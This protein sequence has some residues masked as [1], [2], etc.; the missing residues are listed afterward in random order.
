[1]HNNQHYMIGFL[2]CLVSTC[3]FAVPTIQHWQ[4]KSG[5]KVYFVPTEGLPIL[6]VR[7]VFDAGSVRDGNQTGVASLTNGMLNEG[8]GGL[9][10]QQIAEQLESVGAQL[11]LS[12]SR[13]FASISYRSLTDA[14]A[15]K[16][17]W[18]VLK[19]VLTQPRFPN[20]EFQ[21]VKKNT[22]LGIKKREESP[23]TLAQL[24]LYKA[25]FKNHPYANAI[26]GER[27]SVQS[28]EQAD[29]KRFYKQYYVANN[30]VVV[31]VGGVERK[32]AEQL[33]SELLSELPSGKKATPIATVADIKQGMDIHQEYPSQQTHLMYGM[34]VLAHNDP[35][36]FPL[37]VGNH[38]LGGSGFGSRIVKDIREKRGLAYSAYSYFHPM[39]N[40]GPFLVGL[41]TKNA[42]VTEAKSAI[43][44]VLK[45]FI[46]DGPTDEELLASKK[47]I[48]GGFA[49]K[50]DSNKKLLASVVG[51]VVSG[52]PLDY[53]NSYLQHVKAV[54]R[55]QIKEAFQRRIDMNK[56]VMVTVGNATGDKK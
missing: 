10:A 56:M 25:M 19:K 33:I 31:L 52:A 26:Q 44:N 20:K 49:L 12:A 41:Q 11:G 22:L 24:A 50:L 8:A 34:P 43:K 48:S 35:D 14:S 27:E 21:R 28:I 53:L 17:S 9:S 54:T 30:V 15:L 40:R 51:I 3:S 37:Y 5:A 4:T 38:I 55:E 42:N 39:M 18:A 36:Y 1:M 32:Q 16:A 47:N 46:D 6:D 45:T 23:G 7:L 2:V 13:D 29:L